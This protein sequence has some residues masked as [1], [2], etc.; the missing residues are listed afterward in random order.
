MPFLSDQKIRWHLGPLPRSF[1]PKSTDQNFE[2]AI[3]FH[4][5]ENHNNYVFGNDL[6]PQSLGEGLQVTNFD[7]CL[8]TVMVS[9]K[10]TDVIRGNFW[11]GCGGSGEGAIWEDLS[12]EEYFMGEEK[13]NEKGAGFSSITVKKQEAKSSYGTCDEARR[14]KSQEIIRYEL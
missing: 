10:C 14:A 1:F 7:Q 13:F 6:P 12:L 2:M 5:V 9:G 11:F 4:I 8:H 3:L